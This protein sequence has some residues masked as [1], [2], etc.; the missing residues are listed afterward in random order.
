[1]PPSTAEYDGSDSACDAQSAKLEYTE[2]RFFW[3][4][5]AWQRFDD[6]FANVCTVSFRPCATHATS[7]YA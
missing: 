3:M 6:S 7:A 4:K 5:K 1:M 2:R